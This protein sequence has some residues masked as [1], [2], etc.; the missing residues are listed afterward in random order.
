MY[1]TTIL[2]LNIIKH[3]GIVQYDIGKIQFYGVESVT[4]KTFCREEVVDI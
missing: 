3:T 2:R 4:M 1:D